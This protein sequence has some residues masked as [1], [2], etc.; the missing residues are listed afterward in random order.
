MCNSIN[1]AIMS[2]LMAGLVRSTS[3]MVTCPWAL[4]AMSFL[5]SHPDIPFGVHLTVICDADNYRW[6][7]ITS[8]EK[9]PDLV[10]R[11]GRFYSEDNFPA[12][13]DQ[14]SLDQLEVEFRA[15]IEAVLAAGLKASGLRVTVPK[16]VRNFVVVKHLKG[17]AT[18]DFGAS[19]RAWSDAR[20]LISQ[21][22]AKRFQKILK[23]C[24][25]EFGEAVCTARGRLLRKGHG[26]AYAA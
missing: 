10:D 20:R 4:Q 13:L 15:Q 25:A 11:A 8:K 19:S 6:G 24:W 22:E 14:G 2:A 3:L 9:V 16:D 5:S 21:A 17:D 23:A 18:T 12:F 7:P 26:A 1:E